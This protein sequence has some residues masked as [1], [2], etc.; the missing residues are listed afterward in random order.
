[1]R[2]RLLIGR[3]GEG[4]EELGVISVEMVVCWSGVDYGAQRSCVEDEEKRTED[5]SLWNA[6]L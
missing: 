3:R 6:A 2:Y 4:N 1:M 5:R